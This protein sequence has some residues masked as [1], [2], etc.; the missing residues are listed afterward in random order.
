MHY[1]MMHGMH[2]VWDALLVLVL[3][4]LPESLPM[5]LLKSQRHLQLRVCHV[6]AHHCAGVAHQLREEKDVSP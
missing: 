4:C 3:L 1:L 5:P 2:G 6:D